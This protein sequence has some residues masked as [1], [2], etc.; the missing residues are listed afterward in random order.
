MTYADG[1]A[2]EGGDGL[3]VII[4][5]LAKAVE[6]DA[7]ANDDKEVKEDGKGGGGKGRT[8]AQRP[9]MPR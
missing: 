1:G 5:Y 8:E 4:R 7:D 3:T 6:H 2:G 9:G